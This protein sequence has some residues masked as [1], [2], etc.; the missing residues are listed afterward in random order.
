MMRLPVLGIKISILDIF[1]F[2]SHIY[3]NINITI[4]NIHN[5]PARKALEGFHPLKNIINI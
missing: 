3:Y 5:Q 2:L 4:K 1:Q